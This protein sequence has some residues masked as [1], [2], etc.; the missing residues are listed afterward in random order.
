[1]RAAFVLVFAVVVLHSAFAQSVPK[2]AIDTTD[3]GTPDWVTLMLWEKPNVRTIDSACR[4]CFR[5]EGARQ[6]QPY[7]PS[8][9]WA[10][11]NAS[12]CVQ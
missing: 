7:S 5:P 4:E 6:R 10:A 11:R 12:P 3:A 1:M 8:L 9:Q 2:L